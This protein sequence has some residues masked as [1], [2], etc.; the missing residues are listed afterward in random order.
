MDNFDSSNSGGKDLD[1]PIS[2]GD[3]ET[4]SANISHSPLDLGGGGA[5]EVPEIEMAAQPAEKRV[6]GKMAAGERITGAKT[7]F[8]K[9]HT[10]TIGFLDGQ[11][12]SWLSENPEINI[13][14]T[15]VVTGEVQGKKTEPNII[16]TVW[17]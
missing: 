14:L 5:I 4:G 15:N 3:D 16:I 11:I 1:G 12:T 2:F 10:G 6:A 13:K 9:L 8:T 17:Y 7:F